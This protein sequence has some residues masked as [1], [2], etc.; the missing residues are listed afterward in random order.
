[1]DQY[2]YQHEFFSSNDHDPSSKRR[3]PDAIISKNNV[4]HNFQ[5]VV[6]IVHADISAF[7]IKS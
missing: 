3:T 6:N 2:Q 1:M 4:T 7:A 5:Y